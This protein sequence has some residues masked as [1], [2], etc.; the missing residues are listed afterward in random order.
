MLQPKCQ[1]NL[2]SQNFLL[3]EWAGVAAG[4]LPCTGHVPV[5]I[6]YLRIGKVVPEVSA[7]VAPALAMMSH[8]PTWHPTGAL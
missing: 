2:D 3:R 1:A 5:P 4:V 6:R 8:A 7:K